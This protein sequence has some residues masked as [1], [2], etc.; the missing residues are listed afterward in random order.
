MT[1]IIPL[2]SY[3]ANN[4][5]K[6]LYNIQPEFYN[7]AELT[8][9][10]PHFISIL[11]VLKSKYT[12]KFIKQIDSLYPGLSFHYVMEAKSINI[13]ENALFLYRLS[14]F[15]HTHPSLEDSLFQ[16][17]RIKLINGLLFGTLSSSTD[18][19]LE[20]FLNNVSKT[21]LSI[22]NLSFIEKSE[23][24]YICKMIFDKSF[25]KYFIE[26]SKLNSLSDSL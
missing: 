7:T 12:Y 5:K 20:D 3:S 4:F 24:K 6:L 2:E 15:I 8:K 10:T 14:Y 1:L 17:S 11:S 22:K 16:P 23:K 21:I 13:K 19:S 9:A 18:F 26:L 25:E